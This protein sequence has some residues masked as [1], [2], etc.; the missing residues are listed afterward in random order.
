MSLFAQLINMGTTMD[1]DT[2]K[3]NNNN[4]SKEAKKWDREIGG[5]A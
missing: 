5:G 1:G 2:N 4:E 3:N